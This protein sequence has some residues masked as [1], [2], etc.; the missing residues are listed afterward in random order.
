MLKRDEKENWPPGFPEIAALPR[1]SNTLLIDTREDAETVTVKG[2]SQ[3]RT[4]FAPPDTRR[5]AISSRKDDDD[6]ELV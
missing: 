6:G 1:L 5:S 3:D 4:T 2:Q